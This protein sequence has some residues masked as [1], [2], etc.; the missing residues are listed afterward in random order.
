VNPEIPAYFPSSFP[1]RVVIEI[2]E[3][4][5]VKA[6]YEQEEPGRNGGIFISG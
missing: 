6:F 4:G 5:S 3:D 2:R 1:L